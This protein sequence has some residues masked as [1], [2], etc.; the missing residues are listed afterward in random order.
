[1]K[2]SRTIAIMLV[3]SEDITFECEKLNLHNFCNPAMLEKTKIL[4]SAS[5]CGSPLEPK[6]NQ[7]EADIGLLTFSVSGYEN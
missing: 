4:H 6:Q 1:M 2:I 7:R 5:V 3:R